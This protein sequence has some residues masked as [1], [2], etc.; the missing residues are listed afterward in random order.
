MAT[1]FER[2]AKG[3]PQPAEAKIEQP[4]KEPA[5]LLL[6]W[7]NRRAG[8][9]ITKNDIRNYGPRPIRDREIAIQSAE[10]L[11]AHGHL[12]KINSYTWKINREPLVPTDSQ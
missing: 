1:L 5:Q 6:N 4:S 9:T 8:A 2:L 12:T 7:L 10:V 3:R 11:V